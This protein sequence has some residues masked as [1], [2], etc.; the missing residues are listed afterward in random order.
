MEIAPPAT[1]EDTDVPMLPP[2]ALLLMGLAA[3]KVLINS[4][5]RK[6]PA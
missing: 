6:R 3:Y 4:G 5:N 2:W 1:G